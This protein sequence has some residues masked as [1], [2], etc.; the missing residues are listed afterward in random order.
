M[1]E[2]TAKNTPWP[3]AV[4]TRA[5]SSTSKVGLSAASALPAVNRAINPSNRVLRSI[6]PV[7][8][9]STG[10]EKVTPRA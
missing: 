4:S 9:V 10:A 1:V 6:R 2:P 3:K 5:A 8:A 7:A